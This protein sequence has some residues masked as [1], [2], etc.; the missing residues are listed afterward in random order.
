MHRAVEV[1]G[2]HRGAG[3]DR[4][5]A[6]EEGGMREIEL[7]I[8]RVVLGRAHDQRRVEVEP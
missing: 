6:D 5:V 2:P 3:A 7:E 1:H 8:E 4:H